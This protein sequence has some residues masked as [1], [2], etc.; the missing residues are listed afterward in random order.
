MI[1]NDCGIFFIPDFTFTYLAEGGDTKKQ[2]EKLLFSYLF[3][4]VYYQCLP[5]ENITYFRT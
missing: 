3:N 1:P 5:L 2:V 4:W